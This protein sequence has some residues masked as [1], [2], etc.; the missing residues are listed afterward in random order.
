[1]SRFGSCRRRGGRDHDWPV[2][3]H[4]FGLGLADLMASPILRRVAFVPLKPLDR[5]E[6]F[7]DQRHAKPSIRLSYTEFKPLTGLVGAIV[8][9][10]LH[11]PE[12]RAR[13]AQPRTLRTSRPAS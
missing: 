12:R 5:R 7:R 1:M 8:R 3:E 10:I 13:Y 6:E 9:A 2:D 4:L 11:R